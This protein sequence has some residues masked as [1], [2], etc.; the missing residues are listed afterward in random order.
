MNQ[1]L[2]NLWLN[3]PINCIFNML[4]LNRTHSF[5]LFS[6][7]QVLPTSSWLFRVLNRKSSFLS[8]YFSTSL[9]EAFTFVRLL[10]SQ[11]PFVSILFIVAMHLTPVDTTCSMFMNILGRNNSTHCF[12]DGK[13]LCL[14]RTISTIFCNLLIFKCFGYQKHI[15]VATICSGCWSQV[16][17]HKIFYNQ[18]WTFLEKDI[19]IT[20]LRTRSFI[21]FFLRVLW[22]KIKGNPLWTNWDVDSI[23]G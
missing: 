21:L 5:D 20:P 23:N 16:H 18:H 22:G 11:P 8:L 19:Y 6:Y 13:W 12:D 17:S 15:F 1:R 4:L 9:S 2:I 10:K 14:T 3:E 7:T